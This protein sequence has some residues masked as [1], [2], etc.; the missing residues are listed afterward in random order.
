VSS[1][2]CQR[3]GLQHSGPPPSYFKSSFLLRAAALHIPASP[4]CKTN[5]HDNEVLLF[6]ASSIPRFRGC[7]PT[8]CLWHR[9]RKEEGES[10]ALGACSRCA[11]HRDLKGKCCPCAQRQLS[12]QSSLKVGLAV[13]ANALFLSLSCTKNL[14]WGQKG[15]HKQTPVPSHQSCQDKPTHIRQ[16]TKTSLEGLNGEGRIEGASQAKNV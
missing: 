14:Q 13:P 15:P 8:S 7:D 16:T 3:K 2:R 1:A 4:Q 6:H 9:K 5:S 12:H 10:R 11:H